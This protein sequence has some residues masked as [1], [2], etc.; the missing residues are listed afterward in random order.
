MQ[1]VNINELTQELNKKWD[2]RAEHNAISKELTSEIE[3]ITKQLLSWVNENVGEGQAISANGF[4]YRSEIEEKF[5]CPAKEYPALVEW[6]LANH[7]V[8]LWE[9]K[10]SKS[11]MQALKTEDRLPPMIKIYEKP[12]LSRNADKSTAK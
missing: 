10:L 3:V 7:E 12:T 11:A 9:R 4:K 2:L 1:T 8:L 5:S 6:C